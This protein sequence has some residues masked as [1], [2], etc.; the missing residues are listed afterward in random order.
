MWHRPLTETLSQT[1]GLRWLAYQM[2]GT[3]A[4]A[5]DVLQE[6]WLRFGRAGSDGRRDVSAWPA[7]VTLRLALDLLRQRKR[8]GQVPLPDLTLDDPAPETEPALRDKIGRAFPVVLGQTPAVERVAFVL[9]DRFDLAFDAIVPIL[10]RSPE[11][12]RQAASRALRRIRLSP[13]VQHERIGREIVTAFVRAAQAGDFAALVALLDPDA[14]LQVDAR[15]LRPGPP[16]P[17]KAAARSHPGPSLGRRENWPASPCTRV[18]PPLPS[19]C[20]PPG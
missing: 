13:A 15:L 12:V 14:T 7:T 3:L 18:S 2:L 17:P 9:S 20:P 16:R 10:D 1:D 19:A 8:R 4:D 6:A 11:A 5:E